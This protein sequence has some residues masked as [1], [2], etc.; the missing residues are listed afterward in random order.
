VFAATKDGSLY[1]DHAVFGSGGDGW[2][3]LGGD[4]AMPG[5]APS[6]VLDGED[7][8][9]VITSQNGTI[10]YAQAPVGGA[11][12]SWSTVP[13]LSSNYTPSVFDTGM[14]HAEAGSVLGIVAT[15]SDSAPALTTSVDRGIRL[16]FGA[17]QPLGG[18]L[19]GGPSA[20]GDGSLSGYGYTFI[21]GQGMDGQVWIQQGDLVKQAFV[22]WG[23]ENVDAAA[24]PV[25]AST[26]NDFVVYRVGMD[27]RVYSSQWQLGAAGSP[28]QEVNGGAVTNGPIAAAAARGYVFLACTGLDGKIWLN[29][30]PSSTQLGQWISMG[31]PGN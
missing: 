30:G 7:V 23:S 1:Y 22:G 14:Y 13:G 25:I 12:G 26:G 28:W 24:A 27:E 17:W 31:R 5:T 4:R 18:Q 15:G 21:V 8:T 29:Q 19:E 3:P 10:D 11:F 16:N 9:V 2:K 6:A 20:A